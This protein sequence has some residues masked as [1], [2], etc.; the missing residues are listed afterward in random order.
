MTLAQTAKDKFNLHASGRIWKNHLDQ[1][2]KS[3]NC[4][5]IVANITQPHGM[6]WPSFASLLFQHSPSLHIFGPCVFQEGLVWNAILNVP[7]LQSKARVSALP[8][9][10]RSS[11]SSITQSSGLSLFV[12]SLFRPGPVEM[13]TKRAEGRSYF[14]QHFWCREWAVCWRGPETPIWWPGPPEESLLGMSNSQ[15]PQ[16]DMFMDTFCASLASLSRQPKPPW[17]L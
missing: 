3:P 13:Y 11:V 16:R 1:K 12:T 2:K 15:A 9:L 17:R 8:P 14:S 4:K 5:S 10:L 7:S 6:C